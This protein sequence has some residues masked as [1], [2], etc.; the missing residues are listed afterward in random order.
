M[1]NEFWYVFSRLL[2]F[3]TIPKAYGFEVAT[4]F[5]SILMGGS[6]ISIVVYRDGDGFSWPNSYEY[7][8][9]VTRPIFLYSGFTKG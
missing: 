9:S 7:W 5:Q 8:D 1:Q 3:V 4:R 2:V 6:L